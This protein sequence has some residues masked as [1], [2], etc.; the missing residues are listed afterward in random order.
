MLVN[1]ESLITDYCQAIL[2]VHVYKI[3]YVIRI[4]FMA[5]A[6]QT[7]LFLNGAIFVTY[8]QKS[9]KRFRRWKLP[10]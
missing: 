9:G 8:E 1:W 10:I 7:H 5:T 2:H 4:L 6:V 3:T